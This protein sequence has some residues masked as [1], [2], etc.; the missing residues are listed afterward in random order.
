MGPE[1]AEKRPSDD[2]TDR[3]NNREDQNNSLSE[4]DEAAGVH[5]GPM[6]VILTRRREFGCQ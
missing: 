1:L 6:G 4:N 3:A 5:C 2:K